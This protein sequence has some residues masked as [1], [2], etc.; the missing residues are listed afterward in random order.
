MR[1]T[2]EENDSLRP[3]IVD[4]LTAAA[5]NVL[6]RLNRHAASKRLIRLTFLGSSSGFAGWLVSFRAELDML[7]VRPC[8]AAGHADRK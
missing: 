7:A 5:A 4:F 1:M 6:C 8:M 2:V 3:H